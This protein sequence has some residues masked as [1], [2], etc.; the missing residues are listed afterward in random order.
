MQE[1]LLDDLAGDECWGDVTLPML[2]YARQRVSVLVRL[3]EKTKR[4]VACR[5]FAD[6]IGDGTILTCRRHA[7]IQLGA[8]PNEH[9]RVPSRSRG[10]HLIGRPR[11]SPAVLSHCRRRAEYVRPSHERKGHP[12]GYAVAGLHLNKPDVTVGGLHLTM[13]SRV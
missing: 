4:A 12:M 11:G 7:R 2:E 1:Q 13:L 5:G 10:S 3:V 9:A 8:V 6:E